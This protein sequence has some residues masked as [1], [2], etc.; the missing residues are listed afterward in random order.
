MPYEVKLPDIGEGVAEGEIVALAGEG[1]RRGAGGP[2]AG[3]G[4]DRQGERRDSLAAH[5]HDRRAPRRG[6]PGGAGRRGDHLDRRGGRGCGARRRGREPHACP[7]RPPAP[8]ARRG[9]RGGRTSGSRPRRAREVQATPAVR[10]LAKQLGVAL[11]SV[12]GTGPG[13]GDHR[14]RR[15][16]GRAPARSHAPAPPPRPRAPRTTTGGEERHTAARAAAQDRRAHAA[17]ALDR[18][19]VHVRRRVRLDRGRRSIAR[20]E[21]AR[22]RRPA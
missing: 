12:A 20:A 14:G 18:G 10:Q 9:D 19:A 5:R 1:R 6:G 13:G 22:P 11:E 17:L 4:D 16:A 21:G 2:A 3:R 7:P 8:P 15:E